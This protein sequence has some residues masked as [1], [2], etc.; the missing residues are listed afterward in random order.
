[1]IAESEERVAAERA[2]IAARA[3]LLC[4]TYVALIT[5]GDRAIRA[6]YNLRQ[7]RA[8]STS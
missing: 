6:E 4:D 2:K 5:T 3:Q 7:Q 8:G 1:M